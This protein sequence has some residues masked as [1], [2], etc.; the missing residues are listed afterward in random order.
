MEKTISNCP[1][2]QELGSVFWKNI[3]VTLTWEI[4]SWLIWKIH[5]LRGNYKN[6]LRIAKKSRQKYI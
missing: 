3:L 1:L 5:K 4:L 6:W 2:L